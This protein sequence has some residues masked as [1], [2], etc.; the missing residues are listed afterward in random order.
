MFDIVY[1]I[2][3]VKMRVRIFQDDFKKF[4]SRFDIEP[5]VDYKFMTNIKSYRHNYY[6]KD[7]VPFGNN[8]SFWVGCGHN[9]KLDDLKIDIVIEFNPNKCEGSSLLELILET[10]YYNNPNVEV[11]SF[12]L[13]CD[14]PLNIT[15]IMFSKGSQRNYKMFSRS[16]D[17]KTHYFGVRG[18]EGYLKV[19]NK[20][21]ELKL[22][23]QELTRYEITFKP[24]LNI[25][26]ICNWYE[27]DKKY[28]VPVYYID[29]FQMNLDIDG[30]D[31]VLLFSC[32]EHPEFLEYL[33]R[34]KR[35]KI[36]QLLAYNCSLKFDFSAINSVISM[37]F[38]CV[39]NPELRSA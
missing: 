32:M 22:D 10:F 9:S 4:F 7:S 25:Q 37:F 2:D 39:Y 34:R 21:K 19:Y 12:D 35:K 15:S 6:F 1:S 14:I 23:N 8:C 20:A 24:F 16:Y 29:N 27:V 28:F 13:A 18:S 30:T 11:L 17:D 38:N 33:G 3:M 36:E 26:R 5:S 31:K